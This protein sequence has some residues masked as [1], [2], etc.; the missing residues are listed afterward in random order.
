VKGYQL[1]RFPQ[2]TMAEIRRDLGPK[3]DAERV[4]FSVILGCTNSPQFIMK[5]HNFSVQTAS[6][7]AITAMTGLHT[8]E[9]LR[10]QHAL[11]VISLITASG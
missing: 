6:P 11:S 9:Q 5:F 10:D 2:N 8:V 4:F 1:N 3:S 7:L